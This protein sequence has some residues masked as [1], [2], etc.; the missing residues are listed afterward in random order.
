[1][2]YRFLMR[3]AAV[4]LV[5]PLLLGLSVAFGFAALVA[6]TAWIFKPRPRA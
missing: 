4:L 1:M 5:V 6:S 3:V 2:L